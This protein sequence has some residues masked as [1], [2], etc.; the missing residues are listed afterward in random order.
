MQICEQRF[1]F[2]LRM[3][4]V[5]QG[6]FHRAAAGMITKLPYCSVEMLHQLLLKL[7][8]DTFKTFSL[9]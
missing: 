5:F 2:P 3:E 6:L 7:V 9:R 8:P 1:Y 4:E